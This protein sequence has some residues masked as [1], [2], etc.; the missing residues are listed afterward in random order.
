M[1]QLPLHI[2]CQYNRQRTI[3]ENGWKHLHTSVPLD[4][5]YPLTESSMQFHT[6]PNTAAVI[7]IPSMKIQSWWLPVVLEK[8]KKRNFHWVKNK[9]K[10]RLSSN[11]DSTC[12]KL[13]LKPVNNQLWQILLRVNYRS[14]NGEVSVS[15]EKA[16]I[17]HLSPQTT[18][19]C[20]KHFT[21]N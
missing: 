3:W 15:T 6:V 8:N 18:L 10:T 16:W 2:H 1:W 5:R 14:E 17:S 11:T 21:P 12:G 9:P 7:N 20:L 19:V 13:P 4:G